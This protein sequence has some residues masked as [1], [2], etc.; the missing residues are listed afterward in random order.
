MIDGDGNIR[1]T[2]FGLAVAMD[3][4][5]AIR[6]GTPQYMEGPPARLPCWGPRGARAAGRTAGC[7]HCV[8]CGENQHLGLALAVGGAVHGSSGHGCF[9]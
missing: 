8:L 7:V 4:A 2:D 3:Q 1:I 9:G 5:D 6:A